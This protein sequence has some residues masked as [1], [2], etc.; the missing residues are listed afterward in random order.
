[1]AD[2]SDGPSDEISLTTDAVK[3]RSPKSE[4][5]DGQTFWAIFCKPYGSVR[6]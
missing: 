3:I 2:P 1:M 5:A 6:T 4:L